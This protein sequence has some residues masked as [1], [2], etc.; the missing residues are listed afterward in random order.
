MVLTGVAGTGVLWEIVEWVKKEYNSK[1][2]FISIKQQLGKKLEDSIA[3]HDALVQQLA[4]D[5]SLKENIMLSGFMIADAQHIAAEFIGKFKAVRE[6]LNMIALTTNTSLMTAIAN[7]FDYSQIFVRQMES[8]AKRDDVV[9]GISTSGKSENVLLAL[10][11]AH[12]MGARTI[13]L[14]GTDGD[15][16]AID[17]AVNIPSAN[18]PR[19]QE[20]H[21]LVG[22]YLTGMTETYLYGETE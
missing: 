2:R 10:K 9:I 21:I 20:M 8:M 11:K 13:L 1:D 18:T 12:T 15:D 17:I 16:D 14:T 3:E 22:H 5:N 4:S 19:I 7:D 6:P